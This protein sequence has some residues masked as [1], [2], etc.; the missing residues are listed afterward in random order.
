MRVARREGQFCDCGQRKARFDH[1]A[2]QRCMFLD[3]KTCGDFELIQLLR[4]AS[5]GYTVRALAWETGR[6]IES[7]QVSLQRLRRVGRVDRV[8]DAEGGWNE[9]SRGRPAYLYRLVDRS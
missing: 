2:C 6:A 7:V 8:P 4:Q 3:G 5:D 1:Q 9:E